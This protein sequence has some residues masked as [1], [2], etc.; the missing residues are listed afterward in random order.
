MRVVLLLTVIWVPA[1]VVIVPL[2]VM[3]LLAARPPPMVTGAVIA[4]GVLKSDSGVSQ[5]GTAVEV[6]VVGQDRRA[7]T[8]NQV[9][10][11]EVEHARVTA[12]IALYHQGTTGGPREPDSGYP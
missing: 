12:V 3:A 7:G 8:N 5:K 11:L 10:A 4:N 6:R 1:D 2:R 9:A